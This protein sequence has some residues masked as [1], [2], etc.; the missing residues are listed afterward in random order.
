MVANKLT[1]V[2]I[3]APTKVRP[4]AYQLPARE[5]RFNPRTYEGATAG[6]QAKIAETDVSIHAPTKVRLYSKD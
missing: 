1:G 3:H 5:E 2:S 6:M 4:G